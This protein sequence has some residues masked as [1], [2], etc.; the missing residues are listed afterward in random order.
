MKQRRRYAPRLVGFEYDPLAGLAHFSMYV[1]G[2]GGRERR[3]TT[4]EAK[5]YDDAVELWMEFRA[6]V[7]AGAGRVSPE[8]PTFREFVAAYLPLIGA[9]LGARTLRDYKYAI[10]RHLM[11]AFASL[12]ISEMTAGVL[13]GFGARLKAQGYAG[14]TVNNY[15]TIAALLLGYAVELVVIDELPLK[16]KLKKYRPNKPCNEL[17][18]AERAR[19]LAAFDDEGGF[20]RFVAETM[21]RPKAVRVGKQGFGGRRAHGAGMRND[22]DAAHAYFLRYQRS[23]DLFIVD[24]DSG[25]REGDIIHLR[26]RDVSFA[27]DWIRLEQGKTKREVVIPLSSAARAAIERA[28]AGRDAEP[29]DFVFVTVAGKP[30]SDSTLGRYFSIA[31]RIAGITRRVRFHD[32]RHTFGSDLASAELPLPFIGKVMGHTNPA[33]TAQYARPDS[34]VL[35]RVRQALDRQ[36]L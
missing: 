1:P 3:R 21:P 8:A 35:G 5:S 4:V 16:K 32:L 31:K 9:N 12:R 29:E 20:Q 33:T 15:M 23:K 26:V 10:D 30:Y 36:R 6:R 25:L 34:R 24:L 18:A 22:G 28:L 14:A 2:G 17:S 19:F 7:K 13:N 11:P 27:D